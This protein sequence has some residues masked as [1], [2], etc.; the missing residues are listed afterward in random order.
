MGSIFSSSKREMI[1]LMY[2]HRDIV[3]VTPTTTL[4]RRDKK[5]YQVREKKMLIFCFSQGKGVKIL[6]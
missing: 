1:Q 4:E 2:V 3:V 5:V 6:A